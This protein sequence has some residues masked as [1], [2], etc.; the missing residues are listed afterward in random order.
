MATDANATIS[1][2]LAQIHHLEL[3]VDELQS[4][5]NVANSDID[6]KLAKLDIAG[7]GR[8]SLAQAMENSRSR[9]IELE[10]E[11]EALIGEGGS[12]H[13]LQRRLAYLI[14]PECRTSFDANVQVPFIIN[15]AAHALLLA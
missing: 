15:S 11:L 4:Q 6:D 1:P 8:V 3:Q 14:C 2:L 13:Q 12:V 9:L 10:A 7:M 5:L